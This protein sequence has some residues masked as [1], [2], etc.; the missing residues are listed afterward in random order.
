MRHACYAIQLPRWLDAAE[1]DNSAMHVDAP[2]LSAATLG[3][4]SARTDLRVYDRS[5]LTA[6]IVHLGLGAFFR[7]HGAEYTDAVLATEPRDWGIVGV[8]LQRPDQ[9]DRLQPQDG[10]YTLIEIDGPARSARIIG[11]VLDVLVAPQAPSAVIEH[12]ARPV[13]RIASLTITE[14][15]YCHD[16]ATG[17]LRETHP[18]IRHDLEHPGTPRS[19]LGFLVAA[20][21]E[22]R[23]AGLPPLTLLSCDNLHNNGR[24]LRDLVCS[25]ARLR[26]D[27]LANWIEAHAA[28]PSTMVDRIVPAMTDDDIVQAQALTG[29]ADAAPVM[30]EPFKQW[31][32]EDVFVDNRRPAWQRAGAEFVSA[33]APFE[34]MKLR[35]LNGAHSALAYLGYLGGHETIAACVADP[36]YQRF[37]A[38]LWRDEIIPVT[39]APPGIDL[40]TYADQL[41]AR[42]R[43]SAIR[44][45]TWQI[46]MDG[47]QKLPQRLLA[48]I[49][50]RLDRDLPIDRLA[51]A[52]AAWM[53]YVGG[54]DE[55]GRP[56][57]V[58]DPMARQLAAALHI[59]GS[60]DRLRTLALL[61][62][63]AIFE[64]TLASDPRFIA[65]VISAA[66]MLTA[67]GARSSL[68]RL[69]H[70]RS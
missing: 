62:F 12:L 30:H 5:A 49:R 19:A 20:L 13:T 24:L 63:D 22:R 36:V 55:H 67:H 42:F 18:D 23:V 34:D 16:P 4:R 35:L 70:D 43:N 21:A 27:R 56:I 28:F 11:A 41:L 57:D 45:R 1:L 40:H 52:V 47:S 69:E 44:H 14:K 65:A 66:R 7:A 33:V 31:V 10:L 50:T 15:G 37:V 68:Q 59:A 2:R 46:A 32:I 26:D 39:I 3:R 9:R 64:P 29:L 17:R 54:I 51:L 53:R 38:R 60:D 61:G 58:R 25:F 48:T 6:G 8:S